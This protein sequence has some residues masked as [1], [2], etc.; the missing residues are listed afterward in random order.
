[1]S[2]LSK[3]QFDQ[4]ACE[5]VLEGNHNCPDLLISVTEVA[6]LLM[7]SVVCAGGDLVMVLRHQI[8]RF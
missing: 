6:F 8:V 1:M 4:L 3:L 7:I 5:W 2:L